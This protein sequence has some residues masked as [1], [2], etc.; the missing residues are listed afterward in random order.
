MLREAVEWLA[1]PS[2]PF[3]RRSGH[4]SEFV[5]IAARRRRHLAAWAAHEDHSKAAVL[6]AADRTDTN[7][8][9]VILGAGHLNDVP[10]A[11]LSERFEAVR[12][13]DIAFARATHRAAHALGNV[14]CVRHDVTE[15]LHDLTDIAAPRFLMDDATVRFVASV[16]LL[17]QLSV[18]ATRRMDDSRTD[19]V[20]RALVEAHLAWLR[21]LPCPTALVFDRAIEILG[22]T[23]IVMSR[24]DP[25]HGAELPET[26]ETW[27]WDIAP[28]GEIDADHSVRHI[29]AAIDDLA[30]A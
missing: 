28:R 9:A 2:L 11:A 10:L 24:L 6:R 1:T 21:R 27:I 26:G 20:G 15:S 25:L 30:C 3:A 23:G 8:A 13:V 16:N 12:L 4:L 14:T 18:V 22:P 19:A 29:V 7:G 5:A 17:S